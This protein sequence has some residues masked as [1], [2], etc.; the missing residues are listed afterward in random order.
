MLLA[1]AGSLQCHRY[2][3]LSICVW[4]LVVSQQHQTQVWMVCP[5][6]AEKCSEWLQR[7]HQ[8]RVWELHTLSAPLTSTIGNSPTFFFSY[9]LIFWITVASFFPLLCL[10]LY[11][12]LNI[13]H[14]SLWKFRFAPSFLLNIWLVSLIEGVGSIKWVSVTL[15]HTFSLN[16]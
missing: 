15:T 3:P 9:N 11:N 13:P 10:Q 4:I 2:Q 7:H 8:F 6:V 16:V 14:V 12:I 5:P 1:G